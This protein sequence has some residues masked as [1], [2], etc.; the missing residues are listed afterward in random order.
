MS[1][2]HRINKSEDIFFYLLQ[3]NK[4]EINNK[5]LIGSIKKGYYDLFIYCFNNESYNGYSQDLIVKSIDNNSIKILNY[6]L[7]CTNISICPYIFSDT[8][9]SKNKNNKDFIENIIDHHLNLIP[10]NYPLIQMSID[11]Q[12]NNERIVSLITKDY[13]FNKENIIQSINTNF[14]LAK[15]MVNHYNADNADNADN[16]I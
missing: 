9:F 3:T 14:Q 16:E 5:L 6:I 13:V 4:I 11:M 8:I 10:K 2:F 12:I 1:I 15:V 7:E